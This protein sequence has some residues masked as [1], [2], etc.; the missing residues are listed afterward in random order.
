MMLMQPL[1]CSLG[2]HSMAYRNRQPDSPKGQ[3]YLAFKKSGKEAA[4]KLGE[5]IDVASY[6][7]ERWLAKGFDAS[8]QAAPAKPK[9]ASAKA[10]AKKPAKKAAAK[11]SAAKAK[12]KSSKAK[13]PAAPQAEPAQA[14]A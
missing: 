11:K 13:G 3:I 2:E 6:R 14:M 1:G 5:K 4:R 8:S 12:A 9:A 7:V 10:A